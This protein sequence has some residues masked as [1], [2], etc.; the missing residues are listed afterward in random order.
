MS[1][2]RYLS[3]ALAVLAL[4]LVFFG[5]DG[6]MATYA[7]TLQTSLI[8]SHS[9]KSIHELTGGW[10]INRDFSTPRNTSLPVR[11]FSSLSR[12]I[13]ASPDYL[14]ERSQIRNLSDL[15]EVDAIMT[16]HQAEEDVWSAAIRSGR[17]TCRW[18]S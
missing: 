1:V 4:G 17:R 18:R 16:T 7:A 13:Y 8:A 10:T 2:V 11:K 14:A 15:A 3:S 9:N 6:K 12:G 5:R